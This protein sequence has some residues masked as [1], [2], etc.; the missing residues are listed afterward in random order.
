MAVLTISAEEICR[1]ARLDAADETAFGDALSVL[2]MGLDALEATI[3][4]DALA[5]TTLTPLLTVNAA[6]YLAAETLAL[7]ARELGVGT[8]FQGGGLT[9]G[10]EP[11]HAAVLRAEA[12]AG[13]LPFRRRPGGVHVP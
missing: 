10:R 8:G 5:D 2:E 7:R 3:R 12:E 9:V 6:K 4:P 11:D 13:L 1:L